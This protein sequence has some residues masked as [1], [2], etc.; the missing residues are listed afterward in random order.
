MKRHLRTRFHGNLPARSKDVIKWRRGPP[1]SKMSKLSLSK[2]DRLSVCKILTLQ[3]KAKLGGTKPL[4]G[5]RVG[6]SWSSYNNLIF[7]VSLFGCP[8]CFGYLGPS[9]RSFP[10]CTPL[11]QGLSYTNVPP[12][13]SPDIEFRVWRFMVKSAAAKFVKTLNVEDR[14]SRQIFGGAKEFCRNFPKKNLC[15]KKHLPY[16]F[17]LRKKHEDQNKN[18]RF[19]VVSDS[20]EAF[21]AGGSLWNPL[22]RSGTDLTEWLSVRPPKLN[23][24]HFIS[25][26]D[27]FWRKFQNQTYSSVSLIL[28]VSKY[29]CPNFLGLCPNFQGFCPN[30]W[31]IEISG[32]ALAPPA[33]TTPT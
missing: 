21:P 26:E 32:D 25:S 33:S 28:K 8:P 23:G 18:L 16:E 15:A 13:V 1:A 29:L 14:C 4:T 17:F 27:I 5:P 24:L 20:E 22:N 10:L 6:R 3:R 11:M 7:V 2:K 19:L 30:F 31:Q 9:P 12:V